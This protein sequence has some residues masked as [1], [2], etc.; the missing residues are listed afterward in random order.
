MGDFTE[1]NIRL[2]LKVDTPKNII[3]V[4]EYMGSLRSQEPTILPEHP[5]FKAKRWENMLSAYS[6]PVALL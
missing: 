1:L 3:E 2:K 4:L 6:D 5:L